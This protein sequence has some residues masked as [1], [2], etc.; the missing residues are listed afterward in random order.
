MDKVGLL[1]K[2]TMQ[3]GHQSGLQARGVEHRGGANV[4]MQ[5]STQSPPWKQMSMSSQQVTAA[6]VMVTGE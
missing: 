3:D 2:V 5:E 6:L 4:C 1:R